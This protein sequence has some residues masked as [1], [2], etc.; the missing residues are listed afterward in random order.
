MM[1]RNRKVLLLTLSAAALFTAASVG[2]CDIAGFG[3]VDRRLTDADWSWMLLV[4]LG[5]GAGILAYSLAWTGIVDADHGPVLDRRERWLAPIVG[6]G[7]FLHRGGSTV[8]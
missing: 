8:D 3:A 1:P 2:M 7:G 5:V 4:A 6:F